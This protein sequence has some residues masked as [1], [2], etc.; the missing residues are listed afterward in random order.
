MAL[1]FLRR[2]PGATINPKQLCISHIESVTPQALL[3]F[4]EELDGVP[5]RG[6]DLEVYRTRPWPP[7]FR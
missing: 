7:R 1:S 3:L 5:D 6:A 2:L 4:S